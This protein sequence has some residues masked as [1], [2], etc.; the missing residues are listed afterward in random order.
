MDGKIIPLATPIE[1]FNRKITEV[2]LKEPT[3]ALF[4]RLGEPRV[5]VVTSEAN[6][7]YFVEQPSVINAYVDRLLIVEDGDAATTAVVIS[8]LSL[9]DAL[10]VKRALF[11]FFD[12]AAAKVAAVI[13][14]SKQ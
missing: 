13:S 14:P 8:Q 2:S 7:W 10:S 5:A 9:V 12:N 1:A 6:S 11:S 4:M 3:G